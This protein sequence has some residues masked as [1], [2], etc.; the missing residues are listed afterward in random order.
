MS[1]EELLR[2]LV[3]IDSRFPNEKKLCIFVESF[4]K[5]HGFTTKR[6]YIS[7]DR[8]NL[9]AEKGTGNKPTLFYGHLDTVPLYGKW[10]SDPFKIKQV[11]DKLYGLGTHDM[12]AGVAAI[13]ESTKDFKGHVKLL[14]CVDEENISEGAWSASKK[15]KSWFKDVKAIIAAEAGVTDQNEGGIDIIT[16]GRRGRCV[17]T[18]DVVGR[19]SHG[20]EPERGISALDQAAKIAINIS[21]IP[22]TKHTKLGSESIFVRS[23][24]SDSTSLSVPE[25]ASLDLDMHLVPPNTSAKAKVRIEEYIS[26]L[27]HAGILNQQTKMDVYIQKRKTPYLEP[28]ITEEGDNYLK[29]VVSL[30]RKHS[31]NSIT[32]S[33]G[34]SVADENVFANMFNVPII[35]IGPAGGNEHSQNEWVSLSS[36]SQITNLFREIAAVR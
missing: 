17:V 32:F 19:S 11:G 33:Y 18:I 16:L 8:F 22:L 36:L 2:K 9:L 14:F 12:K 23:I 3:S 35:T 26:G 1:E 15:Y 28:Y 10:K 27:V 29:E 24:R 25:S 31:T 6:D 21:R 5:K 7:K 30:V 20:A 13:L 4:L 34:M